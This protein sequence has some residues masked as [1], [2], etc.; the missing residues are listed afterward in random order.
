MAPEKVEKERSDALIDGIKTSTNALPKIDPTSIFY[1]KETADAVQEMLLASTTV[2]QNQETLFGLLERHSIILLDQSKEIKDIKENYS[3]VDSFIAVKK[4]EN[5]ITKKEIKDLQHVTDDLKTDMKEK[6]TKD[7]VDADTR[8]T[9][10][11]VLAVEK[12][13]DTWD[14]R[15]WRIIFL[16]L[17]SIIGLPV[18]VALIL[19]KTSI[20]G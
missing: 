3:K 4:E 19:S 18:A 8:T 1:E 20:G 9:R 10:Q 16:M 11:I 15:M 2:V 17:G 5:G 6:V 14:D 12:R 13:Q 7:V